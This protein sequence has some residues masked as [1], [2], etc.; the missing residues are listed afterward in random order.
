MKFNDNND[1]RND[2]E[3]DDMN[4]KT[5]LNTSLDV[6]G[7][8]I[9]EDLINR[10]LEAIKRQQAEQLVNQTEAK[11]FSKK[12]ISWNK[13][14]R[15]FAGVAA[16]VLIVVVGYNAMSQINI[17]KSKSNSDSSQSMDNNSSKDIMMEE[18][19]ESDSSLAASEKADVDV[20]FDATSTDTAT[21]DA[22]D[23]I[24]TE[25]ATQ[26][27]ITADAIPM[28]DE[29][30]LYG[31]NGQT[32]VIGAE[33][34]TGTTELELPQAKLSATLRNSDQ[35]AFLTFRD[36]FLPAPEQAEYVMITD[37]INGTAITLTNQDQIKEF[38][39]VMDQHQFTYG[40]EDTA[41]QNYTVE[42]K[43]PEAVLYTLI[44]GKNITVRY[45]QGDT[46]SQNI[47]LVVDEVLF[48]QNLGE[49]YKK[50]SK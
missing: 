38:Y 1:K 18:A 14:I 46:V 40:T 27:T 39:T 28:A 33:G 12:V 23:D 36:I 31:D 7:I 43:S 21:Q 13:Y 5:H 30:E 8:N 48:N 35:I 6:S 17:G 3:I 26:Y 49:F 16:A 44:V 29:A 42:V 34:E 2:L 4:I 15:G 11:D 45:A 32:E 41:N 25:S 24:I 20:E 22:K 50:Y 47:Y 37:E 19:A 9:S 10:T